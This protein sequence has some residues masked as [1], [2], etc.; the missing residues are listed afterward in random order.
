M[1][2]SF[3]SKHPKH[4]HLIRRN[5]KCRKSCKGT[6]VHTAANEPLSPTLSTENTARF[7]VIRVLVLIHL[8]CIHRYTHF[9]YTSLVNAAQIST[10]RPKLVNRS[11]RTRNWWLKNFISSRENSLPRFQL[12]W[13]DCS[14]KILLY[15]YIVKTYYTI[16]V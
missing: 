10:R 13:S 15:I 3:S 6:R 16:T 2:S 12:Y 7:R 11:C 8:W 5:E 1:R 4:P 14:H 9:Y